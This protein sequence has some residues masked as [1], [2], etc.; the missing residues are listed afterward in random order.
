[1]SFFN[2]AKKNESKYFQFNNFTRK[3]GTNHNN[4]SLN[5]TYNNY[6]P[7]YEKNSNNYNNYKCLSE[8]NQYSLNS[9]DSFVLNQKKDINTTYNKDIHPSHRVY[10]LKQNP[11]VD[12]NIYQFQNNYNYSNLKKNLNLKKSRTSNMEYKISQIKSELS[13]INSD[14]IM[15]KEDIYKYTDMNKYIENEIKI[16]KEH[17]ESLYQ[18][19]QSL[20]QEKETLVQ[21][22]EQDEQELN[23]LI[24]ENEEKHKIF[25]EKQL[26]IELNNEKVNNDYDELIL[27]NN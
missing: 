16:Q 11:K 13:S 23:I 27:I 18:K 19:N 25:E 24:Q 14:N 9:N 15:M 10:N 22:L 21:Q 8:E 12:K 5:N 6:Y 7:E 26:N 4:N 1:M 2:R 20:L 3:T 17:N